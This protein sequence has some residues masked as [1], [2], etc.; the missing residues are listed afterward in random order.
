MNSR[1]LA[2]LLQQAGVKMNLKSYEGV[3]HEFFGMAAV[4]DKAKDAQQVVSADL[5]AA[6]GN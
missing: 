2:A 5:K 6:F 1:K 3:T 4:V